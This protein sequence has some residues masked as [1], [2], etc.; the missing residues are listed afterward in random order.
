MEGG[1]QYIGGKVQNFLAC[2]KDH[3][4]MKFYV[5]KIAC[6]IA[7]F[8]V[9]EIGPL[10]ADENTDDGEAYD[11]QGRKVLTNQSGVIIRNDKKYIKR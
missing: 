1:V 2:A 9:E 5:T 10:F 6:G 11:L 3:H 7:G 4:E 8:T